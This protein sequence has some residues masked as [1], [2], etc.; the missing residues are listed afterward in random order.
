MAGM[1][2]G[3]LDLILRKR[4]VPQIGVAVETGTFE[5]ET[6]RLLARKFAT[7]TSIEL[8]PD[9]FARCSAELF[10]DGYFNVECR[11]GNS[12]DIVPLLSAKWSDC[13]VFWYLDAHF[14]KGLHGKWQLPLSGNGAFPLWSELEA[15]SKRSQPDIVI[16]DDIHAF[17]RK[18][19]WAFVNADTIRDL[20]GSRVQMVEMITDQFVVWM[21]E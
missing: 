12:A 8:D 5:G 18:G 7:V 3:K 4:E 17:Q 16:V 14:T 20:L 13:P 10:T 11:L 9:R 15:I 2:A 6:T 19:D 21:T 1:T